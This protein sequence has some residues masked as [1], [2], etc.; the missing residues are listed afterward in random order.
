[1]YFLLIQYNKHNF[2]FSTERSRI[3]DSI[4]I[5][6]SPST[7][8]IH[9]L[10]EARVLLLC[11]YPTG[12]Q[13]F[14]K[15]WG[16]SMEALLVLRFR[17]FKSGLDSMCKCCRF[18]AGVGGEGYQVVELLRLWK[19]QEGVEERRDACSSRRCS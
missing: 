19:Q 9:I 16:F 2:Y 4:A 7:Y 11:S 14:L 18:S 1:M 6:L 15:E 8:H 13:N 17:L 12:L 3:I 10:L 5:S